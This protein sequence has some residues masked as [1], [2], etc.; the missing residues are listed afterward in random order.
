LKVLKVTLKASISSL[1]E[2]ITTIHQFK[3]TVV[4]IFK[5]VFLK[6][7]LTYHNLVNIYSYRQIHTH[8]HTHTHTHI[9]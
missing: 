6:H 1:G 4:T 7:I 9:F 5:R 3:K 8:T 2:L